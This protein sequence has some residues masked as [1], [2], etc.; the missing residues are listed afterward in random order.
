MSNVEDTN[1]F[2]AALT[3]ATRGWCVLPLHSVDD[4]GVC[5]CGRSDCASPGKHPRTQHGQSDA[6]DDANQI[7][8][9]WA[10]WPNANVGVVCRPSGIVV[11]DVDPRNGGD[12]TLGALI[13]ERGA[14]PA[15]LIADTGGG[16]QHYVFQHP[17]SKL[18][19]HLGRGIDIKD[20]GYIV[21]APSVHSTGQ[22]YR[23]R[24]ADA[25][26]AQLPAWISSM[27]RPEPP[28][29][30][31]ATQIKQ[32][33]RNT[34]LTSMAGSMRSRGFGV[35]SIE[36]A[37]LKENTERCEPPLDE[38]EV[39][40][41]VKSIGRYAPSQ[42]AENTSTKLSTQQWSH[43]V[44]L[45]LDDPP[46]QYVQ[47]L[48]PADAIIN[49]Y[50]FA[51]A[52][53][54]LFSLE[55]ALAIH[56]GHSFLEKFQTVP[57]RV[58]IIDEESAPPMLGE[59]LGFLAIAHGID[60]RDADLPCFTVGNGARL[61]TPEGLAAVAAWVGENRLDVL[62]V[63]TQRRVAPSLRENESDDMSRLAQNILALRKQTKVTVV[64]LHHSRKNGHGLDAALMARGS[65]DIMA[66]V[67]SAIYLERRE[68]AVKVTHAKA[69]WTAPVDDFAFSIRR[70]ER[71]GLLLVPAVVEAPKRLGKIERAMIAIRLGLEAAPDRTLSRADCL[72]V[73][74]ELE[75]SKNIGI[76]ALRRL[77]DERTIVKSPRGREVDFQL[78]PSGVNP[79]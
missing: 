8:E 14:L 42:A 38:D 25:P 54:S 9:W 21:V 16:G 27:V 56:R 36:A 78:T 2:D 75:I 30:T 10:L 59:R 19:G 70:D 61:D 22:R 68:G 32:G 34:T 29:S 23:W 63:D 58:G 17:G 40:S 48:V 66:F 26:I 12:Q 4:G 52:G 28:T 7:R 51:G 55:L 49:I 24:D 45:S 15:T 3:Y 53:K 50:G 60:P 69:R 62:I 79:F 64:L 73:V 43:L 44:Q 37:L 13:E 74:A 57:G 1:L 77:E 39:R 46:K 41:I 65:G 5:G 11:L 35:E 71:G 20:D 33:S 72:A 6:T 47:G 18:P 76:E 67:D 31:E